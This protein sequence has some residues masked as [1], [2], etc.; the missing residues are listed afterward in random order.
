LTP[1]YKQVIFLAE[2]KTSLEQTSFDSGQRRGRVFAKTPLLPVRLLVLLQLLPQIPPTL[3][4]PGAE[5]LHRKDLHFA[6]HGSHHAN[7][8]THHHA[9][10][11]PSSAC[12]T[13]LMD[14]CDSETVLEI[15]VGTR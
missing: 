8:A 14:A 1:K 3:I 2:R 13:P 12:S 15:I 5:I 4:I 11:G 9:G 6:G 7:R 10:N